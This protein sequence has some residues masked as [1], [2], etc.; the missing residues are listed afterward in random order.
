MASTS[1]SSTMYFIQ[2]RVWELSPRLRLRLAHGRS[3]V[4]A[5]YALCAG[6]TR[7]SPVIV[8][9]GWDTGRDAVSEQFVRRISNMGDQF[10]VATETLTNERSNLKKNIIKV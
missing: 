3:T 10:I 9:S 2:V 4:C 8:V 6:K 7:E 1:S 5:R